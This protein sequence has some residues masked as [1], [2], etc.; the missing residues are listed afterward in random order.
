MEKTMADWGDTDSAAFRSSVVGEDWKVDGKAGGPLR[1]TNTSSLE[2][3]A[4]CHSCL[5]GTQLCPLSGPSSLLPARPLF[6]Q[7]WPLCF[8]GDNV[9]LVLLGLFIQLVGTSWGSAPCE[10]SVPVS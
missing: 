2:T 8:T 1:T 7:W 5:V 3:F 4:A 10:D 6:P 9:V